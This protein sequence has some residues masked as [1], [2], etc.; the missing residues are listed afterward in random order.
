MKDILHHMKKPKKTFEITIKNTTDARAMP[1]AI[2]INIVS[3]SISALFV[4]IIFGLGVLAAF[5][6]SASKRNIEILGNSLNQ[7]QN[8]IEAEMLEISSLNT[9]INSLASY[10]DEAESEIKG[11]ENVVVGLESANS[12]LTKR[13]S[14]S[15]QST[16]EEKL[17]AT[18]AR[19]DDVSGISFA[20]G[21]IHNGVVLQ[22]WFNG[23][24]KAFIKK[25][26][27]QVI[28]VETG[29]SFE[30][31]RF[32]GWYH[33]DCQPCTKDDTA[34]FK[35]IVGQWTWDRRPIWVQIEGTLYA[36]SMNCMPHMVSPSRTNGFP[37][38]FCI[39]F[40]HSLVHETDRECPRHQACV[41]EA[42]LS[43]YQLQ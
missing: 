25:K 41:K 8:V 28:D 36:A 26:P 24:S 16:L 42:F 29:L 38:H 10:L 22:D 6:Y 9:D 31:E 39:H 19:L 5:K 3:I 13:M 43:A 40:Y 33:A 23:G 34:V 12:D 15:Y 20:S 30:V 32:G 21:S 1:F 27:V 4:C 37:G 17:T 14:S 18:Q 2:K 7:Q 11:Y 35:S